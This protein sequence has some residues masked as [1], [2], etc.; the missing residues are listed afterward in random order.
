MKQEISP[1]IAIGIIVVV[2]LI[3]IGVVWRVYMAPTSPSASTNAKAGSF[4]GRVSNRERVEAMRAAH[5]NRS[6]AGGAAPTN[7]AP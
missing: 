3:A 4:G 7:G 2:I 6:P 5:Q 1:G